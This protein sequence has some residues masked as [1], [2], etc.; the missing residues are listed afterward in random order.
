MQQVQ[1]NYAYREE[2]AQLLFRQEDSD[3]NSKYGKV[4]RFDK[5]EEPVIN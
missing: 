4:P 1:P 5:Y 2:T 3:N